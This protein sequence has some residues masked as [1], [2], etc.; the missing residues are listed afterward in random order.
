MLTMYQQITIKTLVK[1]GVKKTCIARE[2]NCHRNTVA[3]ILKKEKLTGKQTRAKPSIFA[4]F[5]TRIK[6]YLDKRVTNLRIY[7]ILK[8]EYGVRSTYVNLCKY[9]QKHFP[10]P[11][12]AYGVQV[13][14]PG[15]AAEIDFGYLGMLPGPL[16]TLVKTYGLA[17]ILGYSRVGYFAICYDQ[18]LQTLI[19][20]L[21]NAFLYFGGVPKRLKVDNMKTAILTN[22]HYDL[23]FNQDFL[24][25]A[26][27]YNTV[28][29][30]CSPYS[31]E[32]KGTV[33]SGIKYL[34][35]NF[36]NGRTFTDS[37]DLKQQLTGWMTNYA[38]ARVHGT[39]RKIPR[40]VF[41]AEE[42][43][44]LQPL[45]AE[46]FAFFNRCVR[47]VSPNC[48]IHFENNYYSVPGSLTG[49][50]VTVRWNEHLLRVIFAGEQ[51]ALHCKATEQ[52]NYV[53]ER[54]HL[55]DYK[56]Y[57]QT[58]YQARYENEMAGIGG[59][60]HQYFTMLL[61][62]KESYWFRSV[63]IILGLEKEYGKE[64]V[65]L[66]LKRALYYQATDI[67]TIKNILEKK[68]YRLDI[69]PLMVK[70]NDG[71]CL[72]RSLDYYEGGIS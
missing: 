50:E 8:E 66:S 14:F 55:P 49:K 54:S 38:N 67:T 72:S 26:N 46:E 15:E 27:H 47:I 39:T 37:A 58:E 13:T 69:E 18:K 71:D 17:V 56:T 19:T 28:I 1:Q 6:E 30:P 52:G 40:E 53:T 60:A 70:A 61:E 31:P 12:E 25:F 33:E 29:I 59:Y 48:H 43:N 41:L 9:I 11:I 2:L 4:A 68:L 22:Q 65:N 3:N 23:E 7:E 20:E 62:M 34:Q 21:T 51:V 57:S 32:Q 42:K 5:D 44:M 36:I 24:E 45:P 35:G 64:A 63:R 10:K 16:N